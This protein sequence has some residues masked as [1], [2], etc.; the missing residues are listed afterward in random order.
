MLDLVLGGWFIILYL[1]LVWLL[2]LLFTMICYF[3][4]L[5]CLLYCLSCELILCGW[6]EVDYYCE[7]VLTK[8][9]FCF[10]LLC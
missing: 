1:R 5:L 7:F 6:F 4:G 9:L 3:N 2:V 8:G 10:L